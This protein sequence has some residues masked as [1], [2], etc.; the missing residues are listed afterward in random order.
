MLAKSSTTVKRINGNS[1]VQEAVINFEQERFNLPT[2]QQGWSGLRQ[3]CTPDTFIELTRGLGNLSQRK[4]E[5]D[6]SVT[7]NV[8][9]EILNE[10]S[11][12][13]LSMTRSQLVMALRNIADM[14][15]SSERLHATL[16]TAITSK[17][18]HM[19]LEQS[20]AVASAIARLEKVNNPTL[21]RAILEKAVGEARPEQ[22]NS[23][24]TVLH[25]CLKSERDHASK[26]ENLSA[27]LRPAFKFIVENFDHING[28]NLAKL[29]GCC[30]RLSRRLF[31]KNNRELFE[32]EYASIAARTE[33]RIRETVGSLKTKHIV[34]ILGGLAKANEQRTKNYLAI[35]PEICRLMAERVWGELEHVKGKHLALALK[36]LAQL[37]VSHDPLFL[38]AAEKIKQEQYTFKPQHLVDIVQAYA[39]MNITHDTEIFDYCID[40]LSLSLES[41]SLDQIIASIRAAAVGASQQAFTCLWETFLVKYNPDLSF[42]DEEQGTNGSKFKWRFGLYQKITLMQIALARNTSFYYPETGEPMHAAID[43]GKKSLDKAGTI[44]QQSSSTEEQ[45]FGNFLEWL[46]LDLTRQYHINGYCVDFLLPFPDQHIALEF[47][48]PHHFINQDMRRRSR[49]HDKL[50]D[51]VL[52]NGGLKVV[53]ISIDEWKALTTVDKKC[54]WLCKNLGINEVSKNAAA[55]LHDSPAA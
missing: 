15:I 1:C 25:S 24:I 46:G 8:V 40:R 53:R 31:K 14:Q 55:S 35:S 13:I 12:A 2:S 26:I 5:K 22:I 17:L 48:G 52:S 11:Y 19:T 47:D 9:E 23:L 44:R 27:L 39:E 51:L 50:K 18:K 42:P 29:A 3:S 7:R 20:A 37:N 21:M 4:S 49:G 10:R 41:L 43:A 32:A 33:K 28:A 36:A 34:K 45:V 30:G 54:E 6:H 16:A 38:S